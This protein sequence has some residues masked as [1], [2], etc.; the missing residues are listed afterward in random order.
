MTTKQ[1]V[2]EYRQQYLN[3]KTQ[4]A[5]PMR[6]FLT[7]PNNTG[8]YLKY[9]RGKQY[10]NG[11]YAIGQTIDRNTQEIPQKYQHS[12]SPEQIIDSEDFL[13]VFKLNSDDAYEMGYV[14]V[15]Y[16]N[17]VFTA[18]KNKK[19]EPYNSYFLF[20][21]AV[22]QKFKMGVEK[23]EATTDVYVDPITGERTNLYKQDRR[24]GIE[25]VSKQFKSKEKAIKYLENK[26]NFLNY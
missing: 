14:G 3:D 13:K 4:G 9:S 6:I 24:W 23:K 20:P 5:L 19:Q 1:L 2:D 7:Q 10:G 25:G 17:S 26:Y 18:P 21:E 15:R 22:P 16:E 12:V 8:D 11:F